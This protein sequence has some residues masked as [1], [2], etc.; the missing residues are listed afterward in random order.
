MHN[1]FESR[2]YLIQIGSTIES[3]T[4]KNVQFFR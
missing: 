4:F 1:T 3:F 2:S